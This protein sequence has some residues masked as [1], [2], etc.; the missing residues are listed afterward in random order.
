MI[1]N[2][3]KADI[4]I[5]HSFHFNS[6]QKMH[7]LSGHIFEIIDYYFILKR[8]FKVNALIPEFIKKE[9][10]IEFINSHYNFKQDEIELNDFIFGSNFEAIRCNKILL[11]DGGYWFLNR[12][13]SK[14]LGNIFAFACGPSYLESGKQPDDVIF[15]ADHKIYPNLGLD[16]VKKVLPRLNHIKGSRPF[17]HVT[18]NCRSLTKEQINLLFKQYP[19]ILMYSDYL[20]PSYNIT[21]QPIRNF[22]FNR[23]VYTPIMRH[24]DCSP[25]LIIE[26]Q[27]LGIP[28]ELWHINYNDPGLE[29]RLE[30][31]KQ[32]I[33][34][35]NDNIID[36]I[37]KV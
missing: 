29:R 15:L 11:V 33:L 3:S 32:F 26:C 5:T 2:L 16:Y 25:R 6:T 10:F 8:H 13:K 20:E 35:E 19:D 37:K 21:N 23:Y 30:N 18:K 1:L 12:Y 24:F 7:G 17:A 36:I 31:F 27:I 4:L 9:N 14:L 34:Y 28:F 22:N